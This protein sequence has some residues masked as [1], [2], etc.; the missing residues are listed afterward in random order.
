MKVKVYLLQ[1]ILVTL[2]F[3]TTSCKAQTS[4]KVGGPC[5]GCEAILEYGNKRLT[6]TD[7]LPEFENHELKLKV[8]GTVY[9]KD[10]KTPAENVIIYIYHTNRQGIYPTRGDEEGWAKRHGY[11]RGWAKTGKD[12]K[13]TFYT[14]RPASYPDRSEPEHI[15]FTVKEVDRNEYYLDDLLFEDD[16][17]LTVEKRKDRENRGGSGTITLYFREGILTANR[18]IILGLNIPDYE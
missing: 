17:L 8:T 3:L 14:F 4:E 15:H 2:S 5:E 18:N 10:G 9:K 12:G 13:Y 1:V 16:P 11:L 7:T 6:P